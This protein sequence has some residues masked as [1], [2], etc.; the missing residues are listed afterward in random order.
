MSDIKKFFLVGS[1]LRAGRSQTPNN[2][3]IDNFTKYDTQ[4]E[5]SSKAYQLLVDDK[6]LVGVYVCQL[7]SKEIRS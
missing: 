2:T 7:V 3:I 4:E 1:V 5:A 6:N